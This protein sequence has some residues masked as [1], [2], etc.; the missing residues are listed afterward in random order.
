MA[1]VSC[2]VAGRGKTDMDGEAIGRRW[3]WESGQGVL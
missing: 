3:M 2:R 1:E